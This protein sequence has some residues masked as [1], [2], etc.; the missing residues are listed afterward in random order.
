PAAYSMVILDRFSVSYPRQAAALDGVLE[1]NV[2]D[3]GAVEVAGLDA[4]AVVVDTTSSA[5]RWLVGQSAGPIGLSL[6]GEAGHRYLA[7]APGAMRRPE[8]RRPHASDL[9]DRRSRADYLLIA[10]R[11]FLDAAQPLLDLR[12]GQGLKTKAVA[13]ED[14]YDQFGYGEASPAALKDFLS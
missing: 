12:E 3:A 6:R 4:G 10:P 7:V 1:G 11:E 9:R 2:V 13:I 14:V 5:P 8:V